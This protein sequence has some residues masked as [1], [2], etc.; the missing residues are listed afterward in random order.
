ME[1]NFPQNSVGQS[2]LGEVR[3]SAGD[4]VSARHEFQHALRITPNDREVQTALA[5]TNA[6]IDLD[7]VLPE[8]SSAEQLRR[9]QLLLS[10]IVTELNACLLQQV[11]TAVAQHQLDSAR[12]LLARTHPMQEDYT[13][14]LQRGAVQMWQNRASFCQ[15]NV[16]SNRAIDL[17]VG[18]ISNE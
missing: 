13:L 16:P 11:P 7:P 12:D 1:T 17:A 14:A 5:L 15:A 6:V 3:F 4:Y 2:G 10:R 18:R 8:I 9:S